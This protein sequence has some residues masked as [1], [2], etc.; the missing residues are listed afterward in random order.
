M[1]TT[2]AASA[3]SG[4]SCSGQN[5]SSAAAAAASDP[6][7][8]AALSSA[9]RTSPCGEIIGTGGLTSPSSVIRLVGEMVSP[10]QARATWLH[11]TACGSSRHAGNVVLGA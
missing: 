8:A 6:P 1:L 3:S 9:R 7:S 10:H 11:R 2:T 4:Q 5:Q